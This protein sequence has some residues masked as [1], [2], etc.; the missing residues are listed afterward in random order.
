VPI[1]DSG[2]PKPIELTNNSATT[3][4]FVQPTETTELSLT[5]VS[6]T[7]MPTATYELDL[8]SIVFP[9]VSDA[10][11]AFDNGEYEE[12]LRD[13]NQWVLIWN[14]MGFF[15]GSVKIDQLKL[16]VLDGSAR[17][18]C[19]AFKDDKYAKTLYCPQIDRVNGGLRSV[20]EMGKE[21]E[22]DPPMIINLENLEGLITRGKGIG[23]VYQFIDK[24]TKNAIRYIDAK[25]GNIVEGS[26][27]APLEVKENELIEKSTVCVAKEF[28]MGGQMEIDPESA[29]IFYK[30][31]L[32]ALVHTE[33]NK[34]YFESILGGDLSY[35]A[36]TGY[37]DKNEGELPA[38]LKTIRDEGDPYFSLSLLV[39]KPVNLST[40]KVITFG[41]KEWK[42]NDGNIQ[43]YLNSYEKKGIQ[44]VIFSDGVSTLTFGWLIDDKGFLVL[45]CGSKDYE[46]KV[47]TVYPI[48][49]MGEKDG[50]YISSRDNLI[51][52]ATFLSW[53]KY[54]ERDYS[55]SRGKEGIMPLGYIPDDF[56]ATKEDV[57][58][59]F[60]NKTL[61]LD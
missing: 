46:Q 51:A 2:V 24:Y 42:N 50:T 16:V 27:R 3:G 59:F 37:L 23:L 40:L 22:S 41:P 38:G 13:I 55:R 52:T 49:I 34:E 44:N 15:D 7:E 12:G 10:K 25:T 21:Q 20:P 30:G 45:V 36:L 1:V 19:V 61:F 11:E 39:D 57:D 32:S 53:I 35:E 54:M 9:P 29:I 5:E 56:G 26:Y 58:N 60:G 14:S 33:E 6:V 43:E 47:S 4:T 18:V 8:N 17:V 31:F 28:C 48:P